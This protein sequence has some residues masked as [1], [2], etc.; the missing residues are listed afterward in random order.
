MIQRQERMF[1]VII[2]RMGHPDTLHYLP[3]ALVGWDGKGDDFFQPELGEAVVARRTGSL[4]SVAKAPIVASQ[5]PT[6]LHAWSEVR[7]KAWHRE[8]CKAYK[9]SDANQLD[10]PQPKAISI[11]VLFNTFRKRIALPGVESLRH[12]SHHQRVGV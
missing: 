5:P 8:T 3:G 10:R 2:G 4:G 1:K 12:M 11:E 9:I 7:L 6:Y